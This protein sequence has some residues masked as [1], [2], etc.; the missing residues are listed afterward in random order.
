MLSGPAAGWMPSTRRR[1]PCLS[2]CKEAGSSS[3]GTALPSRPDGSGEPSHVAIL[4]AGVISSLSEAAAYLRFS[5]GEVLQL[6][7]EQN[8][9]P[10]RLANQWR[11]LKSAIQQ[12]LCTPP[13]KYS[14]E[15]QLAVAS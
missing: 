13:P 12:W 10:R 5:E 11:F 7:H 1:A 15:A 3:R 14:K 2:E 6:V 4:R 9:P 8:L